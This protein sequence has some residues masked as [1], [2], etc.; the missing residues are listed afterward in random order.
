MNNNNYFKKAKKVR[1]L[2][3]NIKILFFM[4]LNRSQRIK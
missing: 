4:K 1:F 2:N 3:K